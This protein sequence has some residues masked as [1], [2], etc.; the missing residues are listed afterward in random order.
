VS[1]S[2][3]T[4]SRSPPNKFREEL[5]VDD[6]VELFKTPGMAAII[7][8]ITAVGSAFPVTRR[9]FRLKRL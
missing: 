5:L 7:A 2:E 8:A 1:F 3:H 6:L 4:L 9:R